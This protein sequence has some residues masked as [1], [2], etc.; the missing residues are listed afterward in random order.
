MANLNPT[1]YDGLA[2]GPNSDGQFQIGGTYATG[3]DMTS[4]SAGEGVALTAAKPF[5][6]SVYADD[7]GTA[8]ASSW[9]SAG[10]FSYVN[11]AAQA[12]GSAFGLSAQL[13][14]GA[15]FT[16]CDNI[17]GVYG[18]TECDSAITTAA[19]TYGGLFAISLSAGT[20]S[21]NRVIAGVGVSTNNAGATTNGPV[22]GIHFIK[23][24]TGSDAAF[25][26]G[27]LNNSVTGTGADKTAH[28]ATTIAGHVLVYLGTTPGYINVYSTA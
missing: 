8:I 18:V 16:A 11:F 6:L 20:F 10:F 12:T 3:G 24:D 4:A 9:V 28:T 13:H 26:F 23:N 1:L 15:A 21:G 7:G 14:I 5:A 22:V 19:H 25:M 17:A 2:L 27:N